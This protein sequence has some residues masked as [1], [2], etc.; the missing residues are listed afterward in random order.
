[1]STSPYTPEQLEFLAV[2]LVSEAF[3][4]RYRSICGHDPSTYF[5]YA[6]LRPAFVRM[7]RNRYISSLL[8]EDR[9]GNISYRHPQP[10][11]DTDDW[12]QA[13]VLGDQ[14]YS[15]FIEIEYVDS[16]NDIEFKKQLVQSFYCLLDE[17]LI[18]VPA[19]KEETQ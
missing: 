17:G 5:R 12:K 16:P 8:R 10:L 11:P 2:A 9:E 13:I 19:T 1:M 6:I 7:I 4:W 15:V 18:E 3:F 14:L